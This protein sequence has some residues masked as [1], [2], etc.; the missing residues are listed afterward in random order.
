LTHTYFSGSILQEKSGRG[1]EL[2]VLIMASVAL[3]IMVV[4]AIWTLS[5]D[6]GGTGGGQGHGGSGDETSSFPV[7]TA[8]FI[9]GGLLFIILL[10]A[11][12]LLR[13]RKAPA[14]PQPVA[15]S[16]PAPPADAGTSQM[17]SEEAQ[18]LAIKLLSG[19]ERKMFRRI[20]DGGGEV[21]QRDLVAEG[22]FS[23]AKVTRLLDKLERKDLVVRSRYG[24]TNKIRISENLGK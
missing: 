23:K 5:P 9:F 1:I 2:L 11:G 3:I 12:I 10:F 6:D 18:R 15:T 20:V 24:S 17:A 16:Q 21:L 7:G 4:G 14:A 13:S 22:T 8:L 19:D